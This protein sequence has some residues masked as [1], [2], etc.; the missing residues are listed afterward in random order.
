M[1]HY[2]LETRKMKPCT[3][4][5]LSLIALMPFASQAQWYA[6][7]SAGQASTT[8]DSGSRSSQFL[9]LGFD[10]AATSG[11][12]SDGAFRVFAGYGLHRY[13]A[14][15]AGYT[16]LGRYELRTIVAPV[17]RLDSRTRV[18]AADVSVL[19]LLPVG[20]RFTLFARGGGFVSRTRTSFSGS[21][22]VQ[23]IEG[24]D[25]SERSQGL[26]YGAGAMAAITPRW[27]VRLEW[28]RL[29]KAIDETLLGRQD[30]DFWGLGVT[31]RF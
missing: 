10:A 9:D 15:E 19:G 11:D 22:S 12:D 13:V 30:A 16:D 25:R 17:G 2:F 7:A 18:G 4:M 1:T 29:R 21:G 20:E 24:G 6:G 28:T 31:Y 23:V 8:L 27:G 14:I 5:L 3:R 26:L